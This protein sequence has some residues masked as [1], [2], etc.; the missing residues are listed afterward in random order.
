MPRSIPV[1]VALG[2]LTEWADGPGIGRSA[3][4]MDRPGLLQARAIPRSV[5][6]GSIAGELFAIN[7][8]HPALAR[9]GL[10]SGGLHRLAG[11]RCARPRRRHRGGLRRSPHAAACCLTRGTNQTARY[12]SYLEASRR[13]RPIF[14]TIRG[15]SPAHLMPG[16]SAGSPRWHPTSSPCAG[17]ACTGG[18]RLGPIDPERV[19]ILARAAE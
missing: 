9:S 1:S 12:R 3:R 13:S 6:T 14:R 8:L 16:R 10:G 11:R 18:D 5:T 4:R 19:S 7:W 15:D 2:E 17:S